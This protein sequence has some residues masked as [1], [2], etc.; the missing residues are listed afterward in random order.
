VSAPAYTKNLIERRKNGDHPTDV[1][2]CF[3]WPSDWLSEYVERSPFAKNA[4]ILACLENA[5]FDFSIV[6]GLSVCVWIEKDSDA[7]QAEEIATRIQKFEPSR[8]FVL[9]P[10]TG[11][12]TWFRIS[13]KLREA[14]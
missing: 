1:F 7:A 8:L 3:G 5:N 14:A 4:S 11:Q 12:Q 10:L 9:N 2:V 13:Q 6:R